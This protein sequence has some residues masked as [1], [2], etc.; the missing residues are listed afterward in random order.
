ML[1]C[2]QPKGILEVLH[3]P[4]DIREAVPPQRK[5]KKKEPIR[6]FANP[7]HAGISRLNYGQILISLV[8]Y[9]IH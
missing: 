6:G 1:L 7:C 5:K 3:S 8:P 4:E 2:E 9:L